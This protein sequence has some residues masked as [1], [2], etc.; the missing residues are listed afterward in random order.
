MMV[1]DGSTDRTASI[2][3]RLAAEVPHARAVHHPRNLGIGAGIRTCFFES[4]GEWATFFPADMQADPAE[5]PRLVSHLDRCDVLLTYRDHSARTV[6]A[7][8][9][10]VSATDRVLVRA[11]FGIRARDLHWVHFFRRSLLERMVIKAKSP[12]IDVEMLAAARMM[13][14]RI[15]EVP[16]IDRERR[17][18]VARGASLK[19]VVHAFAE[20]MSLRVRGVEIK[21]R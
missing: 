4:A 20:L 15:E 2:M 10:L 7:V 9:K 12:L 17:F 8:R 18:G 3:D 16:L 11:M 5:L 13:G 14:A 21:D 19:N 1:D 6:G